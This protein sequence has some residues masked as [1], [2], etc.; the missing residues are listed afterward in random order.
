MPYSPLKQAKKLIV[1]VMGVTVILLGMA[2]LLLP[3]PG[4]VTVLA[5]LGILGTEF[6]WARRLLKKIKRNSIDVGKRW[7]NGETRD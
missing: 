7:W 2:M 5:G 4:L 1:L 6:L 3:G